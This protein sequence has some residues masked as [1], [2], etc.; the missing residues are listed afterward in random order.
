MRNKKISIT[1]IT[2]VSIIVLSTIFSTINVSGRPGWGKIYGYVKNGKGTGIN[3]VLVE[4]YIGS[5][6][7][8]EDTTDS[9]GRY[10]IDLGFIFSKTYVTLKFTPIHNYKAKQVSVSV[11]PD[12]TKRKDVTLTQFF[13]LL[14]AGTPEY[15]ASNDVIFMQETLIDHYNFDSNGN[16]IYLLTVFNR[17]ERDR[18]A[19]VDNI[20]WAVG[21][22]ASKASSID[23][24]LVFI[25]SHGLDNWIMVGREED[26][27]IT[28]DDLDTS[29]D[30]ITCRSMYIF[31]MTCYS[32]SCIPYLEEDNR[33]IYTSSANVKSYYG[34]YYSYWGGYIVA[35]LVPGT[36]D[37]EFAEEAD[38]NSN[39]KVSMYETYAWAKAYIDY[40]LPAQNPQRDV[41]PALGSGD[42]PDMNHYIGDESYL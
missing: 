28:A 37:Y 36:G 8:D 30:T 40:L 7:E 2:L 27:G 21:Q 4:A 6:K 13:A 17:P 16:N 34:S 3:N 39:Y 24:V 29:L 19:T 25:S 32:G 12:V 5:F 14:I 20:N 10:D 41:G 31:I 1:L 33:A 18:E 35:S 11:Y 9:S 22:I 26:D 15:W 42:Y 23:Q 38:T